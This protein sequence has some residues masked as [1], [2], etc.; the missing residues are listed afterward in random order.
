MPAIL[1]D[2]SISG[3]RLGDAVIGTVYLGDTV[4]YSSGP[5][6]GIK[7]SPKTMSFTETGG[8]KSVKVTS[9]EDNWTLS[10]DNSVLTCT[11]STGM[12][13][14]TI[15]TVTAAQNTGSTDINTQIT[16]SVSTYSAVTDV[17][18]DRH[19][20]IP[21]PFMFNYNAK[22]YNETT[23]TIPKTNGQLFDEDLNLT[24]NGSGATYNGECLTMPRYNGVYKLKEYAGTADNPFNRSAG[25]EFT[26]VY[27][28]NGEY[29][30][31]GNVFAN[32]GANYNYMVRGR[33]FHTSDG[34]F[35]SNTPWDSPWTTPR[36][37]LVRIQANGYSERSVLDAQGN[38]LNTVSAQSIQWGGAS[39]AI[40]FFSG[41]GTRFS[42]QFEGDF[43][44]MY[45][46]NRAL[47]DAEVLKVIQYNE[48]L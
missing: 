11:P 19:S 18:V 6:I 4:V 5:F 39:N 21:M 44:W 24:L 45:L 7:M 37:M 38:V 9:S 32:R 34:G 22:E 17:K 33:V 27:K 47:T 41:Y 13:G 35:L 48:N 16:A 26:V 46:S 10:Y 43:Y 23:H 8:T 25:D 3:I 14:E 40:G 28:V 42:E 2:T 30:F 29:G 36:Y 15:V 20:E 1:G 12:S 31:D